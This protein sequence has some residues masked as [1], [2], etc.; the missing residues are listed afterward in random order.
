MGHKSPIKNNS[1]NK[2]SFI[3]TVILQ[4]QTPPLPALNQ[5]GKDKNY[6]KLYQIK[7]SSMKYIVRNISFIYNTDTVDN[8][9][10]YV[11]LFKELFKVD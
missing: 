11:G 1:S 3:F 4:R 2:I 5:E 9:M 6:K 8:F 7:L 10:Q